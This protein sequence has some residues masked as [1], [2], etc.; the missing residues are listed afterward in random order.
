MPKG[1]SAY[2]PLINPDKALPPPQSSH[3]EMEQDRAISHEQAEQARNTPL[4]LHITQPQS[5]IIAPWF[6]EEIR[7]ELEKR[8][9]EDTMHEA[10]L[11]VDTTLDMDLQ[12]VANA[13][14]L[15]GLAAY[16]RRHGWKGKLEN[17][18]AQ[19]VSLEAYR[20]SEV[21]ASLAAA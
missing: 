15:D 21:R 3:R 7:K 17:V 1:P 20:H 14:V 6:Q 2:S 4:G 16:E 8:L 19:G 12:K 11:R 18:L 13:A 10:G 9:G 5:Q